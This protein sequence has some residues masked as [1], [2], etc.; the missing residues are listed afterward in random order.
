MRLST[1][2]LGSHKG[3]I[4]DQIFRLYFNAGYE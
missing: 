2:F 4:L 1:I 3:E